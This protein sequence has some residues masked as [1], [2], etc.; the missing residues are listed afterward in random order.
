VKL[1]SPRPLRLPALSFLCGNVRSGKNDQVCS[2]LLPQPSGVWRA[3]T[4][5][6][7]ERHHPLL[8]TSASGTNGVL[9]YNYKITN[10]A[11]NSGTIWMLVVDLSEDCSLPDVEHS[12]LPSLRTSCR[13][14]NSSIGC[15]LSAQGPPGWIAGYLVGRGITVGAGRHKQRVLAGAQVSG[16]TLYS[17]WFADAALFSAKP[18]IAS[19]NINPDRRRRSVRY[20]GVMQRTLLLRSRS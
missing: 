6:R 13:P 14:G 4:C 12:D 17:N 1:K 10:P 5:K 2:R 11:N 18:Y 8:S 3:S 9:L 15:P 20:R 7:D 19:D 16:F